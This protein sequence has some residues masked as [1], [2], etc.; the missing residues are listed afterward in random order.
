MGKDQLDIHDQEV[1]SLLEK[2]AIEPIEPGEGFNSGLFVILKRTGGFR[3][4][5]VKALNEFVWPVK[6]KKEG[7]PLLEELIHPVDLFTKID[8]K[9]A[10]LTLALRKEDRKFVQIKWGRYSISIGPG[11]RF[12][13]TLDFY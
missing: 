11:L 12:V 4:V 2:G 1:K 9:D 3:P 6:L 5:V 7:I 10:Y 13:H 8:L